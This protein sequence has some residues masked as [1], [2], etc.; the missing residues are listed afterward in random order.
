VGFDP[1]TAKVNGGLGLLSMQERVHLV[2][3][4]FFLESS[5]GKGTRILASVPMCAETSR[6]SSDGDEAARV[7]GVA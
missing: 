2:R 4:E 1:E 5:P 6:A 7:T 3:G